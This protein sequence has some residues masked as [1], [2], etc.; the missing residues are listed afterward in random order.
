MNVRGLHKHLHLCKIFSGRESH[1]LA[2]HRVLTIS[3]SEP[4]PRRPDQV[5][6][7]QT[8]RTLCAK[9]NQ[10]TCSCHSESALWEASSFHTTVL[11]K[12]WGKVILLS[13]IF[14]SSNHN[15]RGPCGM[16]H[17]PVIEAA[18]TQAREFNLKPISLRHFYHPCKWPVTRKNLDI[19]LCWRRAK[20]P[21]NIFLKHW[22]VQISC[23]VLC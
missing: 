14:S 17:K 5:H 16:L 4:Q 13:H 18:A 3:H 7:E 8:P 15:Y 19:H 21:E 12:G 2:E 22:L 23:Q 20:G 9:T 11:S 1:L 6:Q 10:H